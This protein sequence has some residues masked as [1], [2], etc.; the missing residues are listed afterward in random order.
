MARSIHTNRSARLLQTRGYI[1]WV[2]IFKKRSAK[3]GVREDR[4]QIAPPTA[5]GVDGSALVLNVAAH[6]PEVFFPASPHDVREVLVRL[7]R[8]ASD[9]LRSIDFKVGTLYVNEHAPE[10]ADVDPILGRR[11]WEITPGVYAPWVLGT[12]GFDDARIQLFGY[13]KSLSVAVTPSELIELRFRMLKTV[14][15]E[16]A[17]HFDRARRV[18]RGRWSTDSED[19]NERYAGA[20][21]RRWCRDVVVPYL[22]QHRVV[23]DDRA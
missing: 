5:G 15:H 13:V 1:D 21:T 14:V 19:K 23:H 9:G 10:D 8:G 7:P 3:A 4:R 17:H 16:V 18:A 22:E 11:G 20:M 2:E 12:Y 6:P